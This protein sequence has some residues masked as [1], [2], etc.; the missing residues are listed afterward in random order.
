MGSD[1]LQGSLV[2][3]LGQT[4]AEVAVDGL[5]RLS[6]GASRETWSFDAV[7]DG[8]R[9]PLILQRLRPGATASTTA[10]PIATEAALLR[11]AADHGVPVAAVVADDDGATLGSPGMV[12]ERLDGETIARKLL[13][14]DEYAVARERLGVQ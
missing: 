11:V 10:T 13:R 6:G 5:R 3:L 2:A 4:G 1:A 14:D 9:R 8:V 7:V 12:V